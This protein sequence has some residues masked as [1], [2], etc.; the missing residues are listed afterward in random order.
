VRPASGLAGYVTH[1]GMSGTALQCVLKVLESSRS[2]LRLGGEALG[3]S[4]GMLQYEFCVL[5]YTRGYTRVRRQSTRVSREGTPVGHRRTAVFSEQTALHHGSYS[6]AVR[7]CYGRVERAAGQLLTA[8]S[9][10]GF[11]R[12][13]MPLRSFDDVLAGPGIAASR[14]RGRERLWREAVLYMKTGGSESIDS[15]KSALFC[16]SRGLNSPFPHFGLI[17]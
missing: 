14:A 17:Q 7:L 13:P 9:P 11:A 1:R 2:I 15:Q 16:L 8:R 12:V 6:C 4:R 10:V 5:E 3:S